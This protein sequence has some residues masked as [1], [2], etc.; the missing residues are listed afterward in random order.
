MGKTNRRETRSS[1]SGRELTNQPFKS[2]LQGFKVAGVGCIN[3][4][5]SNEIDTRLGYSV[6]SGRGSRR[7]VRQG[8]ICSTCEEQ[9]NKKYH[10]VK[11][12]EDKERSLFLQFVLVNE[13]LAVPVYTD[14]ELRAILNSSADEQS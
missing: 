9:Q 5:C 1:D 3:D 4:G 14:T 7:S 8:Y 13:P 10:V 6:P 11:W 2:A 12:E